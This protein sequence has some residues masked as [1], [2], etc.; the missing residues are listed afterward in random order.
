[1]FAAL[2]LAAATMAASNP[3]LRPQWTP[4]SITLSV[5]ADPNIPRSIVPAALEEAAAV[6]RGAGLTLR[7]TID[8]H[9]GP[10]SIADAGCALH[11]TIESAASAA[12]GT[13][14]PLGWIG[15]EADD[16]T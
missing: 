11:V 1:M 10:T 7:W 13:T 9:A 12:P 3:S 6:W 14:M 16:P 5:S 15:F 8:E 2:A 4:A